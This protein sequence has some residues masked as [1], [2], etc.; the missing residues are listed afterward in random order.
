M[1]NEDILL[2]NQELPTIDVPD[3]DGWFNYA[4]EETIQRASAKSKIIR[5]VVKPKDGMVEYQ[6]KLKEL[7]QKHAEKDEYDEPLKDIT[8]L[9][10]GRQLEKYVIPDIDNPKGKFNLAAVALDKKYKEDIDKY[11]KKLEFLE[12]ENSDF[13]PYFITVDQIP[14][15]LSRRQMR[16]L[17]LMVKEKKK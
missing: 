10:G 13:E 8:P 2:L 1:K 3:M 11:D 14:N 17:R 15:G 16:A 12:E 6:D 4:I 9:G 5:E 7:Q